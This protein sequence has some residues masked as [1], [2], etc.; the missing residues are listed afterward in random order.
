MK[1]LVVGGGI[2]GISAAEW[3][4]RDGHDV[5]VIDRVSPGDPAQA[6]YGNCGIVGRSSVVPVSTPGLLW[7]APRMLLDPDTMLFLN[8]RRL[9]HVLPWLVPML[10]NGRRRKVE[11]IA[12][13]LASLVCDS[14]DQHFALANGTQ[15]ESFLHRGPY[16]T[17]FRSNAEF[18]RNRFANDLRKK[19]GA[20]W[21][22]W[23]RTAIAAYDPALSDAYVF[24]TAMPDYV[25]VTSPSRYVEA[26]GAHF[27]KSGG[28]F[29]KGDVTGIG[30]QG[31][32]KAVVDLADG[33]RIEADRIVLAA[34]VWSGS[35]AAKLGH[36][37]TLNSER[38]YH[39]MLTNPSHKPPAV[40][41]IPDTG[42]GICPMEEGLCFGGA[43]DLGGIDGKPNRRV[44]AAIRRQIH[45]VYPDLA[46]DT[47]VEWTGQR[48]STI[49][50]LP[51]IGPSPKAPSVYF[52]CGGQHIGLTIGPKLGRTVASMISGK[53]SNLNLRPF[54]VD[55]FD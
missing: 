1:V 16:V 8:W 49:D 36:K 42:L 35:L 33:Q 51:L 23:D 15:A 31:D 13:A 52:A 55:R 7:K 43:V 11:Q 21:E 10:W 46:W 2:T 6:S 3:L 14:D 38:G 12:A 44:F 37:T 17:L 27:G 47:E 20:V 4:R 22:E 34:G 28:R 25:F 39:L 32:D 41:N 26:L 29:L 18:A 9:R 5:T 40:L 30:Q 45:R 24:A 54:T 50:S 19:H 53:P 48:P